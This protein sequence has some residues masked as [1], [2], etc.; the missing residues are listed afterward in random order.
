MVFDTNPQGKNTA[1]K[2]LI[3]TAILPLPEREKK[4]IPPQHWAGLNSMKGDPNHL[5]FIFGFR[6]VLIQQSFLLLK[7]LSK[8]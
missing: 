4:K 2:L 3:N 6:S 1:I 7:A 5:Y 8:T